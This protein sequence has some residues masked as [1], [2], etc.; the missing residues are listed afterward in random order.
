M[1]PWNFTAEGPDYGLVMLPGNI[2]LTIPTGK[3]Y[4]IGSHGGMWVPESFLRSAQRRGQLPIGE[5]YEESDTEL[6]RNIDVAPGHL[7]R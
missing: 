4:I 6:G 7:C 2:L 3:R 5:E 1:L